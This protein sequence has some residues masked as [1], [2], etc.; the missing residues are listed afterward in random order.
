MPQRQ[1]RSVDPDL[2][3]TGLLSH[4][5]SL[6]TAAAAVLFSLYVFNVGGT[7]TFLD[8]LFS[9]AN[10]SVQSHNNQV[11]NLMIDAVPYIAGGIVFL[12]LL[13]VF[14]WLRKKLRRRQRH[15]FLRK[16]Q[17][18]D[19]QEF[20]TLAK[21]HG[22]SAKVAMQA[23]RILKPSYEGDMRAKLGDDL[24]SHLQ[25]KD[26]DVDV[27]CQRLLHYTDRKKPIGGAS[28]QEIRTVE[29]L[30]LHVEKAPSHF[31][32]HSMARRLR[33]EK[34]DPM[35]KAALPANLGETRL[36]VPLHKLVKEMEEAATVPVP[37]KQ[38]P[39]P[40]ASLQNPPPPTNQTSEEFIKPLHKRF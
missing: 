4:P 7:A 20:V 13:F 10:T 32:T 27:L 1:K 12:F 40:T 18:V 19:V 36:L 34:S 29:D 38:M 33:G 23:Y 14:M 39:S 31:I 37:A 26:L 9:S 15:M 25:M 28:I 2:T 11:V 21:G 24:R 35:R 8:N 22:I 6:A 30:M 16:R 17:S 3:R 5:G